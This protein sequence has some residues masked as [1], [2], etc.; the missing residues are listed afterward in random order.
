[1]PFYTPEPDIVHEVVG[2]A[3]S[4]ASTRFAALYRAAGGAARRAGSDTAL[5]FVSKVFWFTLEFGVLWED[6]DLKAYGA[7]I[8]SSYGE[9]TTFRTARIR[10]LDLAAM[11]TTDYDITRYQPVLYAADSFAQVEDVVGGFFSDSEEASISRLCATA[12]ETPA[13][14]A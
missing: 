14:A 1:V 10:P 2:H 4:L 3:N 7:G 8:L 5:Q 13:G 9:M 12:H 6:G 11:G